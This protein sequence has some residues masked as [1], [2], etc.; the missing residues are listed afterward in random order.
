MGV[1][2]IK[3]HFQ[4]IKKRTLSEKEAIRHIINNCYV[5]FVNIHEEMPGGYGGV[6]FRLKH[7]R[8]TVTKKF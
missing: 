6:Q 2:W 8:E 7:T 3:T 5:G 4:H 1:K